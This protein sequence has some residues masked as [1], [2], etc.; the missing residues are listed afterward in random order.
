M[1]A[2]RAKARGLASPVNCRYPRLKITRHGSVV[3]I[4]SGPDQEN[5]HPAIAAEAAPMLPI[6]TLS[7]PDRTLSHASVMANGTVA[8]AVA[9]AI[10]AASPEPA[11][12]RPAP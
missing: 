7:Q 6:G 12:M 5:S 4:T 3:A 8:H 1:G 11:P 10:A 9:N 2:Q